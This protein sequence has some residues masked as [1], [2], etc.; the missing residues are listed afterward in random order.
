[1]NIRPS[2]MLDDRIFDFKG[3]ALGTNE[4]D[5]NLNDIPKLR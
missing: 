4:F 2:H 3:L 5:E 1:M